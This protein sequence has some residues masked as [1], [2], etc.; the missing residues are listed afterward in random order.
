MTHPLLLDLLI[1]TVY[2]ETQTMRVY[3]SSLRTSCRFHDP[4]GIFQQLTFNDGPTERG[5]ILLPGRPLPKF[6]EIGKNMGLT[7]QIPLMYG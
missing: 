2:H 5:E 1:H 4:Y 3:Y 7:L 6:I